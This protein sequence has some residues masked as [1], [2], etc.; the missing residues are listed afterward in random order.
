[1]YNFYYNVMKNRYND[2]VSLLCMDTDSLI[3]EIKTGDFYNDVKNLTHQ[4][5]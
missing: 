4:I 1:M 5:T 2:K 3:M